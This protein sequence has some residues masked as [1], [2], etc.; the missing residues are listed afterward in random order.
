MRKLVIFT[1]IIAFFFGQATL[2]AKAKKDP[3]ELPIQELYAS[4]DED[5]KV[6]FKIP[7]EV[8]LLDIA[9]DCNWY[10]VRISFKLGPFGHTYVGWVPIPVAEILAEKEPFLPESEEVFLEE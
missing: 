2:A 5:S 1:L 4:P 8:T 6:I 3:L 10:K 7:M 9:E